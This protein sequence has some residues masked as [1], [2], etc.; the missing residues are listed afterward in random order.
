MIDVMGGSDKSEAFKYFVDLTIRGFLA[1]RKYKDHLY[2]IVKL[3]NESGMGCFMPHS[4]KVKN[5]INLTTII[6]IW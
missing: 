5:P 1:I 6:D 2:N 4:M 3:I